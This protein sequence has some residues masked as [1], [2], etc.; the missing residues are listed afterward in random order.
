MHAT[1]SIAA[2]AYTVIGADGY[3]AFKSATNPVRNNTDHETFVDY[4]RSHR[5][6]TPSPLTRVTARG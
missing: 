2:L 6:L 1:R 3:A 4:L 5:I